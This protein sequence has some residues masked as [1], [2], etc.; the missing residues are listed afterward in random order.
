[1]GTLINSEKDPEKM[2]HSDTAIIRG[3][4]IRLDNKLLT[5]QNIKNKSHYSFYF[6]KLNRKISIKYIKLHL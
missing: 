3:L 5:S 4:K 6:G 1:M 2:L